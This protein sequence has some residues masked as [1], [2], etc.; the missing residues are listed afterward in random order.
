MHALLLLAIS[1]ASA[2]ASAQAWPKLPDCHRPT[3]HKPNAGFVT[4]HK[5]HL[6]LGKRLYDFRSFNYPGFAVDKKFEI[7]DA[8]RSLAAF[9]SPVTRS[10]TLTVTSIYTTAEQAY[11]QAY[12]HKK[13]R[14]IFN[15]KKFRDLDFAFAE[16]ARFGVKVIFPIINADY[17][18]NSTDWSGNYNV[19][20]VPGSLGFDF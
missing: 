9:A 17:G 5:H 12:D 19:T 2:L 13:G 14:W 15:E 6:Y 8:L 20:P 1:A 4:A 10:Y 18:D 3:L 7:T 16:A 11:I